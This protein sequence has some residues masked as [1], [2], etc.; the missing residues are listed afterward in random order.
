MISL[1]PHKLHWLV[2]NAY[3]QPDICFGLI[4]ATHLGFMLLSNGHR[5]FKS[6][7]I[8]GHFGVCTCK[9]RYGYSFMEIMLVISV[10]FLLSIFLFNFYVLKCF[11]I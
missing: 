8:I 11:F 2:D 6:Q 10:M 3:Q 9:R 7:W 1:R 5:P 4:F